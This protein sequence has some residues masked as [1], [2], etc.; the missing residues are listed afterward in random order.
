MIKVGNCQSTIPPNTVIFARFMTAGKED[1]SK[2][3]WN[4]VMFHR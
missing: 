4:D 3:Y 1:L 2:S